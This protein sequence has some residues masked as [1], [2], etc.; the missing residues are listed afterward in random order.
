[1]KRHLHDQE[2]IDL[3][4]DLAEPEA[5]DWAKKHLPRCK[6]CKRRAEELRATLGQMELAREESAAQ[7]ELIAR[8]LRAARG[9]TEEPAAVE[10]KAPDV[11]EFPAQ[12]SAFDLRRIFWFASAAAA[13]VIAIAVIPKFLN[14]ETQP[15]VASATQGSATVEP[16]STFRRKTSV[17]KSETGKPF[18]LASAV[19]EKKKDAMIASDRLEEKS[20]AKRGV[21]KAGEAAAA[22]QPQPVAMTAAVVEK[23]K[24]LALAKAA[25]PPMRPAAPAA[26][27]AMNAPGAALDSVSSVGGV[28][29]DADKAALAPA[30]PPVVEFTTQTVPFVL[31]MTSGTWILQQNIR[32]RASARDDEVRLEVG[33]HGA[34]PIVFELRPWRGTNVLRSVALEPG[35]TTNFVEKAKR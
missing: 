5:A 15:V 27:M 11:L 9:E 35:Q 17:A 3:Q 2:L 31:P 4:F 1:M 29:H 28:L 12:S 20:E 16:Q 30:E 26:A 34:L 32:V 8:T 10:S 13:A 21:A 24:Q 23:P 6:S 18:D 33:N 7:E 22:P 25:P 19:P 14:H